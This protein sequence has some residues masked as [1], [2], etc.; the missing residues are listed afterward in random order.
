MSD[1]VKSIL[2]SGVG[3][4]GTILVSSILTKGLVRAG[5]DVKMSE[6]H[7]MAQRGGSVSTQVRYGTKVHSPIIGKGG[8]DFL[9]AFEKMEAVRYAPYLKANGLAIVNDY[10]TPPLPVSSG[11]ASYPKGLI[12]AMSA[13]YRTI[14]VDAAAVALKLGNPRV[15]N[16]VLFGAM[17][18]ALGMTEIDW[19][20]IL[21][22]QIPAKVIEVNILA[23]RAGLEIAG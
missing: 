4:Q 9:V 14:V 20:A 17:V 23:Y 1:D 15:M 8:A 13:A 11:L 3:G 6:V 2:L 22:E 19:E 10:E 21:R 7:G 5:Y 18:K 12:E 16:I